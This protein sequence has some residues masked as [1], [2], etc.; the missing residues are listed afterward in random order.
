[1]LLVLFSALVLQPP[2]CTIVWS[3]I[4]V[5]ALLKYPSPSGVLLFWTFLRLDAKWEP[6]G[7][8]KR[9]RIIYY[10]PAKCSKSIFWFCCT[11]RCLW[12]SSPFFIGDAESKLSLIFP[13][14]I[15]FANRTRLPRY[16]RIICT[17]N[18]NFTQEAEESDPSSFLHLCLTLFLTIN[19][20]NIN[21][22]SHHQL[23]NIIK[24][25]NKHN[26]TNK[27]TTQSKKEKR[28]LSIDEYYDEPLQ[29]STS[30]FEWT[31]IVV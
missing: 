18:L 19:H 3:K 2:C 10:F 8:S 25:T 11:V 20:I 4:V 26:S 16:H 31:A 22:Y 28:N 14:F 9:K 15:K 7:A 23:I 12:V 24:Q 29:L 30:I 21:T 6:Q 27:T 17:I 13:L 5:S 1:M